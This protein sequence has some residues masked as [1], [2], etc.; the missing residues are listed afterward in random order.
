MNGFKKAFSVAA[1][2]IA[3]FST[4]AYAGL[5]NDTITL[6]GKLD[7]T[8]S[9][10]QTKTIVAGTTPEFINIATYLNF[11]FDQNSLTITVNNNTPT[12]AF[13]STLGKFVFSGFDETITGLTLSSNSPKFNNFGDTDYVLNSVTN[14]ISFD[15]SGVSPQNSNSTLVFNIGTPGST[16]S[17]NVPEPATVALL[18]LGLLGAAAARRDAGKRA[19]A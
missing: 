15:F 18:G 1:L 17:S 9:S 19:N 11:N 16:S 2:V 8:T 4:S 10:T 3:G 6:T 14:T 5:I 7:G 13:S 12:S